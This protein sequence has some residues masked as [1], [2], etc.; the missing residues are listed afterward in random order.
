M[1][2]APLKGARS[3]RRVGSTDAQ[4]KTLSVSRAPHRDAQGARLTLSI[5]QYAL[6]TPGCGPYG[7]SCPG[8]PSR[9]A[10]K[11]AWRL[12]ALPLAATIVAGR[13]LRGASLQVTQATN[14]QP[15]AS[16]VG[17]PPRSS[18]TAT[19]PSPQILP[20]LSFFF[21]ENFGK[22]RQITNFADA[23]RLAEARSSGYM[24]VGKRKLTYEKRLLSAIFLTIG[25]LVNFYS[26]SRT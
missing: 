14:Y 6:P 4:R 15:I 10:A 24:R 21:G 5:S 2:L 16:L 9:C 12:R 7:G 17:L 25:N 8:P 26:S 13:M 11:A 3:R 22:L 1:R 18:R 23:D 20:P 19:M